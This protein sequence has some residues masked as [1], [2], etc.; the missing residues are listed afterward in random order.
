LCEKAGISISAVLLSNCHYPSSNTQ[1]LLQSV[2]G[3]ADGCQEGTTYDAPAPAAL[4]ED[5]TLDE[6]LDAVSAHPLVE[7]ERDR[8]IRLVG[9]LGLSIVL[10]LSIMFTICCVLSS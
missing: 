2:P 5:T 6:E 1:E 3:A 8:L 9:G 4:R 10:A 7:T